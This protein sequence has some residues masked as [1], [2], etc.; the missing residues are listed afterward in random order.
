MRILELLFLSLPS[1]F[2]K[3]PY[4]LKLYQFRLKRICGEVKGPLNIEGP[5]KGF[6]RNVFLGSHV[7][8]NGIQLIGDG[9]LVIGDYFHSGKDIV[10]FT[11]D[12][13]YEPATAIPYGKERSKK[14]VVIDDFVWVGHGVIILPGVKIGEGAI[15]GA[16]SIVTKDVPPLGIVGGNPARVIKFRNKEAYYSLKENKKFL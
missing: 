6:G 15:L 8:F 5:V 13:I 14:D 3:L 10:I 11:G 12:H 1:F 9:K 2:K 16:G 4:K 7:N